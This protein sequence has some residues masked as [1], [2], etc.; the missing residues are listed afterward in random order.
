MGIQ[1]RDYMHRDRPADFGTRSRPTFLSLLWAVCL[2]LVVLYLAARGLE[3]GPRRDATALRSVP[4]P[5]VEPPPPADPFRDDPTWHG[6]PRPPAVY[7]PPQSTGQTQTVYKCVVDGR[8]GYS[9]APDCRG[10][11][12]SPL[13]IDPGPDAATVASAQRQADRAAAQA[14]RQVEA[15]RRRD[16]A[17]RQ[18]A[19]AEAT[20][21][22]G[23]HGAECGTLEQAI[24]ALDDLARRPLSGPAQDQLRADR[25]RLRDR[26]NALHC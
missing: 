2:V 19:Y 9:A 10:G 20:P 11:L 22:A 13:A 15:M 14:A 4:V 23:S 18:L 24:R 12:V 8:T 7:G 26:Q 3:G 25:Q 6:G 21:P 5:A 1:D 17:A 16:D